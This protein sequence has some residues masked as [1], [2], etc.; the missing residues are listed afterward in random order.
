[1]QVNMLINSFKNIFTRLCGCKINLNTTLKFIW[2]AIILSNQSKR[3]QV[4]KVKNFVE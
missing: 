3:R 2:I 1:M 4:L